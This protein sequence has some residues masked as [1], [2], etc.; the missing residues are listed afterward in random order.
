MN[1]IKQFLIEMGLSLT[2]VAAGFA[3]AVAAIY[4]SEQRLSLRKVTGMLIVGMLASGYLTPF[5]SK[6]VNISPSFQNVLSFLV[7]MT[8]MHIVGGILKI[9]QHFEQNPVRTMKNLQSGQSLEER[10]D[11]PTYS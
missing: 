4:Q 6:W 1:E 11:E 10:G 9:G 8:G 7:G 5:L 2:A 3:G